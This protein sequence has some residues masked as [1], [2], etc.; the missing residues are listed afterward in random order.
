MEAEFRFVAQLHAIEADTRDVSHAIVA[1]A[2]ER[3][4]AF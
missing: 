1:R 3:P 4:G 2:C